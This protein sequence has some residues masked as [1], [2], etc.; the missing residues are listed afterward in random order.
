MELQEVKRADLNIPPA[1]ETSAK[2]GQVDSDS[3]DDFQ[4]SRE[5]LPTRSLTDPI[6]VTRVPQ[7]TALKTT[8]PPSLDLT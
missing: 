4:D 3:D 1:R 7:A 6:T 2:V 5:A 8:Q